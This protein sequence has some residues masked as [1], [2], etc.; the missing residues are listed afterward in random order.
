M[1]FERKSAVSSKKSWFRPNSPLL[2]NRRRSRSWHR[3][4]QSS[5]Q[6]DGEVKHNSWLNFLGGR[7][8]NR[9]S[10]TV[11]SSTRNTTRNYSYGE[12]SQ[13]IPTMANTGNLPIWLLNLEKINR[14]SSVF[15]FLLVV[16]TL[17]VY[18]WT[19]YSQELW[20]ESYR[21]LQS[22]QRHERQLNTA[23]ATLTSKM[24]Q[25]AETPETG[26]VSPKAEGTIFL[27]PASSGNNTISSFSESQPQASQE[28][29]A[30]L[31][32]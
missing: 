23:N 12:S 31:G 13:S 1:G 3:K 18:G 32:Y 22:L 15:A 20:S 4:T 14:Y 28:S 9:I 17:V 30:P 21:R 2:F 11:T 19:V 5:P 24:A 16:A 10:R 6:L 25:E 27:P 7:R 29:P 8:N 26:L